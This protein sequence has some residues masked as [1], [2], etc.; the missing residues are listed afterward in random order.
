MIRSLLIANRGEIAVR[1]ARTA[2]EM[3]IEP[4]GVYA[5]ADAGAYHVGRIGRAISLGSGSPLETYLSIPRILEAARE[6]GADALHPGYGFL[7]ESAAFARVVEEAG[8]LW[9]GPPAAAIEQMGDKLSAR[10]RARRAGVTVVPGTDGSESS[11]EELAQ[12]AA[13]IGFPLL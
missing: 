8:I 7:S 3:G 12:K 11:D 5:E 6:A 4:V 13:E 9:V 1:I 10:R 2:A